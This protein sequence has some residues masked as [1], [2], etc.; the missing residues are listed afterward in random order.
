MNETALS[1]RWAT[2]HF[3]AEHQNAQQAVLTEVLL[4][5]FLVILVYKTVMDVDGSN[6]LGP[7][8]IGSFLTAAIIA[9]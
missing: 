8:I 7:F 2:V 9:A 3:S 4:G 1:A 5:A 6:F